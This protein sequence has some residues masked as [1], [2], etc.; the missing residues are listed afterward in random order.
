MGE[1]TDPHHCSFPAA[2]D[3]HPPHIIEGAI[4]IKLHF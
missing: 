2:C 3:L 1:A 4:K